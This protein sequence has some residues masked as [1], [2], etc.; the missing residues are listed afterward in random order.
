MLHR[1]PAAGRLR[2]TLATAGFVL[3]S[4]AAASSAAQ[5]PAEAPLIQLRQHTESALARGDL[6]S[7]EMLIETYLPAAQRLPDPTW[8]VFNGHLIACRIKLAMDKVAEAERHAAELGAIAARSGRADTMEQAI[9]TIMSAQVLQKQGRTA[10]AA[11]K[12]RAAI[13]ALTQAH[14][15]G[16]I[17]RQTFENERLAYEEVLIAATTG[18]KPR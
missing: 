11:A 5:T 9:A 13:S 12:A 1:T 2:R 18:A 15:R 3:C 4:A 7:A 10:D 16:R 6:R 17:S 14:E 8:H